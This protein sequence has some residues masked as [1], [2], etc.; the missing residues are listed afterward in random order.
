MSVINHFKPLCFLALLLCAPSQGQDRSD[1]DAYTRVIENIRSEV[2]GEQR[3]IV[4]QL[5]KRYNSQPDTHYPVIYRLDGAASLVTMNAVL[6][7]LQS[8]RNAPEVIIVAI[9]NT[10][11]LRDLFPTVNRN[12]AGP[13]GVGGGGRKFLDFIIGELIP[14]V[15]KKYRIHDFRVIEGASAAGVFALYALQQKPDVFDAALTYSAA[16]WWADGAEALSTVEFLKKQDTLDHYL[17]TAIGNEPSPMRP[18]YDTMISGIRAHQ[19]AG[20]RW[21]NQAFS[22]VPHDLV[23]SAGSFTAYF[24]LFFPEVMQP[25]HYNGDLASITA[26]YQALSRQRGKV[27][28]ASEAAIRQ[29]GYHFVTEQNFQE[30]IKLFKYAIAQYPHVPDAYNGLAYGYEQ[31]G[32]FEKALA[33][34]NKALE[35]ASE[36]HQGYQVYIS[37][38][39]R[40]INRLKE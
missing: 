1:S 13:L 11:R 6:E 9:E 2:M 16:V 20:L 5:P 25:S 33:Q 38:Q 21:I 39:Q 32:E 18:Y 8:Q 30:A 35:L 34:V 19:P 31:A 24:N 23:T 26:Y 10:D 14:R 22:D 27:Y 12:P 28:R 3:K 4:V 36:D 17:Y 29:L 37:R 7:S 40:L 15:E